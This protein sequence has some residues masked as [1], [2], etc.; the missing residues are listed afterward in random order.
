MDKPTP[1]REDGSPPLAVSLDPGRGG[2]GASTS[3]GREVRRAR[4][5]ERDQSPGIDWRVEEPRV[6]G[7]R[8]EG[9]ATSACRM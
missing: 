1:K 2:A 7:R 5:R 4:V 8:L 3:E 9:W 6:G